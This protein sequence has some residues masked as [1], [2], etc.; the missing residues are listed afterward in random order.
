MKKPTSQDCSRKAFE[1]W[2]S[3]EFT[4]NFPRAD[5][6]MIKGEYKDFGFQLAWEAWQ[7][8]EKRMASK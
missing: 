2:L 7:E 5:I 4:P 8:S 1:K 6:L 3:K